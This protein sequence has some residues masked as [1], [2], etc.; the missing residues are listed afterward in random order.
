MCLLQ[1]LDLTSDSALELAT[2]ALRLEG[3]RSDRH[4]VKLGL[5]MH[6]PPRHL[7]VCQCYGTAVGSMIN[8]LLI[9]GVIATKRSYLDGSLADPT[10]QWDGRKPE[11]FFSASVIWGLIG[12][13]LLP[14]RLSA[15]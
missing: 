8:F 11:I 4:A 3:S 5:Y 9:R 10:Q 2:P 7:F 1:S 13:S 14:F 6:V 15:Y 12:V